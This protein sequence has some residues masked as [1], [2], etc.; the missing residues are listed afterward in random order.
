V[1]T[2]SE[3]DAGENQDRATQHDEED[4]QF[5]PNELV[6]TFDGWELYKR[7]KVPFHVLRRYCLALDADY[8]KNKIT[9]CAHF[10]HILDMYNF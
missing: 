10:N 7:K 6:Q 1:A 8:M 5:D 3:E 9:I 2:N 4:N